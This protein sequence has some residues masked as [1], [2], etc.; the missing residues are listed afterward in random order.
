MLSKLFL[1]MISAKHPTSVER[2]ID[3]LVANLADRLADELEDEIEVPAVIW[4]EDGLAAQLFY[5][6]MAHNSN[7]FD[8]LGTFNPDIGYLEVQIEAPNDLRY[9]PLAWLEEVVKQMHVD[10]WWVASSF[11]YLV[12]D[13]TSLYFQ[14]FSMLHTPNVSTD[15]SEEKGI[16]EL[17]GYAELFDDYLY[18]GSISEAQVPVAAKLFLLGDGR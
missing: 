16:E 12:R 1:I 5:R 14:D 4:H 9:R 6:W 11:Y 10:L 7:G 17:H 15:E 2:F 13:G 8:L 3:H 18:H